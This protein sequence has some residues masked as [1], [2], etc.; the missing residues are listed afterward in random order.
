MRAESGL[1]VTLAG[2]GPRP[3]CLIPG[4]LAAS[5]GVTLLETLGRMGL[6]VAS[7]EVKA[8]GSEGA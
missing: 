4:G 5:W 6:T 3:R 1:E 8:E 2:D 7:L